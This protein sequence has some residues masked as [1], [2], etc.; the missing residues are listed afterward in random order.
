MLLHAADRKKRKRNKLRHWARVSVVLEYHR[1][2][3]TSSHAR[4]TVH[5]KIRAHNM[6]SQEIKK[7]AQPDFHKMKNQ[8]TFECSVFLYPYIKP[9][10]IIDLLCRYVIWG[11]NCRTEANFYRNIFCFTVPNDVTRRDEELCMQI[12][13]SFWSLHQVLLGC[14]GR[15][16]SPEVS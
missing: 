16:T 5:W 14:F 11:Q 10:R 1:T 6:T 8:D 4:H 3:E 7:Q 15:F 9:N 12:Y 2:R 13:G